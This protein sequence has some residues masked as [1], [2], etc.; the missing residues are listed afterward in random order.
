[1]LKCNTSSSSQS[2]DDLAEEGYRNV[3][4]IVGPDEELARK[5]I[6]VSFWCIQTDPSSR[7][8][9][10]RVVEMLESKVEVLQIPP[11]P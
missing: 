3:G 6:I 9:M 2:S 5:M 7:P 8:T 10:T 1:M 11:R 4:L